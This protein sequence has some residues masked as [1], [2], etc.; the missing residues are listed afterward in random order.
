MLIDARQAPVLLNG[1]LWRKGQL[2][3]MSGAALR[4]NGVVRD[5]GFA[6]LGFV[7]MSFSADTTSGLFQLVPE[8]R[9]GEAR[10]VSWPDRAQRLE[11]CFAVLRELEQKAV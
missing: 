7:G 3:E 2:F 1:R 8:P 10:L 11:Q 9:F 4:F 5:V 6:E